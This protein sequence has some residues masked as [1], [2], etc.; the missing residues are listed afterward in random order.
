MLPSWLV[1]EAVPTKLPHYVLPLCTA[2]AI[3]AVMAVAR[4]AV[5]RDRPG[6]R[7]VALLVPFIPAGLTIGL[8]L[9]AW[10]LDGVIP[11]AGLPLLLAASAVAFLAWRAFADGFPERARS[12]SRCWRACS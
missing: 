5:H 11:W 10:R 12:P 8:C 7:L 9:A 3:L 4:G 6:A 2:L 1:F